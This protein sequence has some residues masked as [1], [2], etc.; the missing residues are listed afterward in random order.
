M[1]FSPALTQPFK[2]GSRCYDQG[3]TIGPLN[4]RFCQQLEENMFRF[5]RRIS[6]VL[7]SHLGDLKITASFIVVHSN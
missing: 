5:S 2:G 3:P 6:K 7:V 1:G 4:T